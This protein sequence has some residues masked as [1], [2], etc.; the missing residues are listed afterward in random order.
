L[1][2]IRINAKLNQIYFWGNIFMSITQLRVSNFRSFKT[3]DISLD[4]LNI[5]I[6]ANA[7]GKSNFIQ[8][9][10]FLGD[11]IEFGLDD[12]ISMQ[13][14]I[15]YL[16]NAQIGTSSPLTI[17][18]VDNTVEKARPYIPSSSKKEVGYDV[19]ETSYRFSIGFGKRRKH[20]E[21]IEDTL[22]QK[23]KFYLFGKHQKDA[24][25]ADYIGDGEVS[26]E[27]MKGKPKLTITPPGD[28]QQKELLNNIFELEI[29]SRLLK[30]LRLKSKELYITS[31]KDSPYRF[32]VIGNSLRRKFERMSIYD[33][34]PKLSKKAQLLTGRA[35]LA[36]DGSNLAI[37]INNLLRNR[38]KKRMLYNLISELLPFVDSFKIQNIADAVIFTL[39]EKYTKN[40]PFPAYLL[41]D[42]TINLTSLVICLFFEDKSL[43]I[44]EEPERNI[45]P[46]LISKIMDFMKEASKITQV[47]TTT[48]NPEVVRHAN[49]NN[50]LLVSRTKEGFSMIQRPSD[51][52]RVKSFLEQ[53]MG[54]EELYI[55]N[56]L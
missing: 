10:K 50:I 51:T 11:L 13:G 41:S 20:F 27:R 18:I 7:S 47:I 44:I 54:L 30:G 24:S 31:A 5:L 15:Q 36:S 19:I 21:I 33:F 3:I 55:Q 2:N 9:F 38:D 26:I 42:G 39:Q 1:I 48:H 16:V 6:G 17:E 12:A 8:I 34:D 53:E 45:H 37:V 52:D 49:I 14:G 25:E 43:K 32:P 46:F 56:L 4:E 28:V 23:C 35:E 40:K 22:R 29:V